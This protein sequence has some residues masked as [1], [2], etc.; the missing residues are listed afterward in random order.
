MTAKGRFTT[1]RAGPAYQQTLGGYI[2][3][4][5]E[6]QERMVGAVRLAV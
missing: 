1:D 6:L 2:W 3:K 4:C 5:K